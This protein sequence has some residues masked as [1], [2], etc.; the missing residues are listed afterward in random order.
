MKPNIGDI[1]CVY[2]ERISQFTACQVTMLKDTDSGKK[3]QLAAILELDWTG[4]KLP[5]EAELLNMKPL[6][7]DFYFWNDK[8][9]HCLVD[10]NVPPH[11]ILVGN[12][13]PLVTEETNSYS[14]W[15]IG[16]STRRQRRW[17]L[18]DEDRRQR[19]KE[20]AK[21]NSLIEM[22]QG[23][24]SLSTN[25]VDDDFLQSLED[26][27]ELE[28]LPCLTQIH[29]N[30]PYESLLPFVISNPIINQLHLTNH[31]YASVDVRESNLETLIIDAEGL[32]ELFL[33][34]GLAE[35]SF[36]G[37][38]SPDLIIHAHNEGSWITANCSSNAP[39]SCGLNRLR[40]LHLRSVTELDLQPIVQSFPELRELRIWGKPGTVSN[41][42]SLEKLARLQGFSTYDMFGFAGNQFPGPDQ[43]SNL[44]WLW[45]TS[46][47]AEAAQ[48][49]K[50]NYKKEVVKGLDL[51]ISKPRKPEWLAE[52]VS[53]P[54]RDW[55]G[56]DN[57]TPANAKKAVQLYKKMIASIH[58]M[59]EQ[60][61]EGIEVVNGC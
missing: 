21:D 33:N 34:E 14:G 2:V 12:L 18:I 25:K 15:H 5:D 49:I 55:D 23:N 56:R 3:S 19:F 41:I 24:K 60:R 31:G 6:V 40:C 39:I 35:L 22:G 20:A 46:L 57:I 27:F 37:V 53:N 48:F 38:L 32:G 7:C 17:S 52:N 30:G 26:L 36:V 13:P 51:S 29:A 11:Y 8:L 43:M 4:D 47:P 61:K 10:A 54:F 1:Y 42:H 59:E 16:G 28:K 9:D 58:T 45:M 50:A 44:S